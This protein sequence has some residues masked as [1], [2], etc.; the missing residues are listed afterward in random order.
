MCI[1]PLIFSVLV[2]QHINTQAGRESNTP[3]LNSTPMIA[4]EDVT[5]MFQEGTLICDERHF[6]TVLV[7][8]MQLPSLRITIL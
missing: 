4:G 2:D 3:F 7:K 5:F 6:M 8:G 1:L